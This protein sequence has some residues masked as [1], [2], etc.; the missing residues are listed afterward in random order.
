MRKGMPFLFLSSSNYSFPYDA[1]GHR[2][3]TCLLS[4][5]AIDL[6]ILADFIVP[7]I[8][9]ETEERCTFKRLAISICLIPAWTIRAFIDSSKTACSSLINLFT[10]TLNIYHHDTDVKFIFDRIVLLM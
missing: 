2:S 9:I 10:M 8:T 3:F 7:E 6:L 5:L 4:A 1:F